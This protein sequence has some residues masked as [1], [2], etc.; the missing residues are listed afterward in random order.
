M[1]SISR[2]ISMLVGVAALSVMLAACNQSG[3]G[4]SSSQ[5]IG[6]VDMSVLSQ[7]AAVQKLG[8]QLMAGGAD[9]SKLKAAYEQ[10]M[11]LQ[12]QLS[13]AKTDADKKALQAKIDSQ[14]A[15]FSSM[16]Q[17]AQQQQAQQE[18]A[19]Q[20]KID[21]AIANVADKEGVSYVYVKQAVL[22]GNTDDITDKVIK[23]LS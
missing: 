6:V 19:M 14:K 20:S 17:N 5:K 8:E 4:S 15:A 16:M 10:I 9:Q 21:T 7:S 12:K 2:K 1:K 3:G 18:H 11:D 22:Y 23:A 13:S